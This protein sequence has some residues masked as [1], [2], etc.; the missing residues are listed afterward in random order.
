MEDEIDIVKKKYGFSFDL[1]DEQ[2]KIIR[3]ILDNKDT[4]GLLPTGFGKSVGYTF[5]PLVLDEV[6]QIYTFTLR[7]QIQLIS[8]SIDTLVDLVCLRSLF[9]SQTFLGSF[10]RPFEIILR[11]RFKEIG[12]GQYFPL[13]NI[14]TL[15]LAIRIIKQKKLNK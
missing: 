9:W 3:S 13:S 4:L 7:L 6:I 5:P 12:K 11:V 8:K 15:Y 14:L 2:K 1:K 10:L